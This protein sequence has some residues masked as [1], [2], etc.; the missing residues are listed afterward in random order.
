MMLAPVSV[1]APVNW[2]Y[3]WLDGMLT[4]NWPLIERGFRYASESGKS[5]QPF[6]KKRAGE[7]VVTL[8]ATLCGPTPPDSTRQADAEDA[9]MLGTSQRNIFEAE[10]R[11]ACSRGAR[12]ACRSG[13]KNRYSHP[14]ER[15]KS[16]V[17]RLENSK[18]TLVSLPSLFVLPHVDFKEI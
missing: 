9:F 17:R 12:F 5:P 16:G 3:G 18:P 15:S 7:M 10:F 13:F 11:V 14:T 2:L 8:S 4:L 6:P 1:A